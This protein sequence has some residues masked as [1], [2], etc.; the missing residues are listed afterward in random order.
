MD[1]NKSQQTPKLLRFADVLDRV[2]KRRSWTFAAIKAG[3]FPAPIKHG[4][5]I[6]FVS[7]EI[8]AWIRARIADRDGPVAC[9]I[10]RLLLTESELAAALK[11][12]V[13]WLQKDRV[14]PQ[15]LPFVK[16]GPNIRYD[17]EETRKTLKAMLRGGQRATEEATDRNVT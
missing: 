16:I 8:D 9:S 7:D 6:L 14:G 11:V 13:S 5:S 12:S 2:G 17:L 3:V 4:R 15:K 10:E 1:S